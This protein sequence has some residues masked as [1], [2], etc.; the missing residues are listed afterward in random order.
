ML[1]GGGPH[2]GEEGEGDEEGFGSE[3]ATG[4]KCDQFTARRRGLL[5]DLGRTGRER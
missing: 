5:L 1:G 3:D 4:H 2:A